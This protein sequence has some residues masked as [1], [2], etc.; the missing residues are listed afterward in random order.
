MGIKA[1]CV[2]VAIGDEAEMKRLR[3]V[4][5]D[6]LMEAIEK[7]FHNPLMLG[8]SDPWTGMVIIFTDRQGS[9]REAESTWWHERSHIAWA[10]LEVPDKEELGRAAL[11]WLK[12]NDPKHY[13][14]LP[15]TTPRNSGPRKLL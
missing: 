15:S 14:R 3:G 4:V 2:T 7:R 10:A 9:R 13:D 12:D 5:E 8:V 6:E 1:R 11:E